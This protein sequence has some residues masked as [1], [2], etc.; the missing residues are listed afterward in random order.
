MDRLAK[1]Y[2]RFKKRNGFKWS[3]IIKF[4][5]FADIMESVKKRQD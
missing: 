3:Q 2:R 4:S 5:S 1:I